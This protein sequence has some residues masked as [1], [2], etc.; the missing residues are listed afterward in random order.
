MALNEYGK[1]TSIALRHA[2]DA[3]GDAK[4]IGAQW[5]KLNYHS[6]PDYDGAVAE[7]EGF[8]EA[9]ALGGAEIHYLPAGDGLTIDSIYVRDSLIPGP[10]GVVMCNMGKPAR[11]GEPKFNG[12]AL[13]GEGIDLAGAVQGQGRI[14]GG[15]FVWLDDKTCAVAHGYRTNPAGARQLRALLGD[16]VHIEVCPLPHYK[17]P[18]DVF[19]LMSILSPLDADLALVYSPLMPV[20]FR[21]WLLERGLTLVEV[22][23]EEFESMGCNVLATAPRRCIAVEGNPETRKRLEAAGCE[24]VTYKGAEISRKGEGGP[25]CLTRPLEREA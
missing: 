20:P 12:N 25:T 2:R 5:K 19:H 6:A 14:E 16:D 8:V 3:F 4:T 7:Y 15:D 13:D 17:G 1:I 10:K 21:N 9:L 22:P 24:V 11:G 23:D 18:D